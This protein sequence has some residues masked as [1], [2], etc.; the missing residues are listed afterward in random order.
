[1]F[2]SYSSFAER[3]PTPRALLHPSLKVPSIQST[4]QVP[5]WG[6]YGE[7]CLSPEP[8]FTHPPGSP[9]KEPPLQVPVGD[10]TELN[11]IILCGMKNFLCHVWMFEIWGFRMVSVAIMVVLWCD[12]VWFGVAVTG[13]E[14]QAVMRG[15]TVNALPSVYVCF[16]NVHSDWS[17]ECTPNVDVFERGI[18]LPDR[19]TVR[20]TAVVLCQL[21]L[22]TM[23]GS[24]SSK[25]PDPY[26]LQICVA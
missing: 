16:E 5:Q 4:F 11:R 23:L 18:M 13:V 24:T 8:S 12:A 22:P 21:W 14:R 1:M 25:L 20:V 15:N 19:S 9:V 2:P 3:C 17:Y 10:V 6:P 7:R 26:N